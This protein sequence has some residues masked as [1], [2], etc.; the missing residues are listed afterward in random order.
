M[1]K[2]NR[3]NP[4]TLNL[5]DHE[6]QEI[7]RHLRDGKPLPEKYRF[8]LFEDKREVEL[9]WNGKTNHVCDVELPFQTIERVDEP[10]SEDVMKAQL[11]IMDPSSGRQSGGWYNK[12]IWGD[13]NLILSSLIRGP[14]REQIEEAGGLKLI[15]I[16]PPFDVGADFS[17][18]IKVGDG[19]STLTKSPNVLEEIAYRDTWGR[20][21][22]SF[23]AMI[24]ERL[25]LMRELLADDGSIY[26]HCDWRL[27]SYLRI[28][29]NEVFGEAYYRNEIIW[30][31]DPTGKG[32][33]RISNQLPKEYDSI[34]FYS[35][36][37][38]YTF[39]QPYRE[40]SDKQKSIYNKT[41]EG[42]GRKFKLVTLG[43]Y[44]QKS[45]QEMEA[46]NLIY[47]TSSGTKYKKYYLDESMDTVGSI[48]ADLKVSTGTKAKESFGYPTQKT[49]DLLQRIIEASSN[50]GDLIA[51]FFC[52]SGTT[53]AVAEKLGRKWIASDLGKFAIHTTR[54][55]LIGVQR[56]L[57][58]EN[59]S[60]RAFEIL[61][62]GKYERQY[63]LT[64]H[65]PQLSEEERQ[66][67]A[68]RKRDDYIRQILQAYQAEPVQNDAVLHGKKGAVGV[69]VGP[70]N[71]P[72]S[73]ADVEGLLDQCDERKITAV[74]ILAFE[75]EMNLFPQITD[76]AKQR[77]ITLNPKYIPPEVFD[78]RAVERGQVSFYDVA[79][80]EAEASMDKKQ[81]VSV[82]LT[83]FS[84]S[85]SQEGKPGKVIVE[86]GQIYQTDKKGNRTLL[87]KH[88]SDWVDYWAVDYNYDGHIFKNEWQSF[89]ARNQKLELSSA[90][91]EVSGEN[92]K[93][94][95]KVV[96]ILGS[97]TLKIVEI[98]SKASRK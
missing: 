72:V 60:Y 52:G 92:C 20:G 83:N 45:I 32:A 4:K 96:D 80:I 7:D 84:T 19:G 40:L 21:A 1:P 2:P 56:H 37:D 16:D 42:T 15:Y 46:I 87:T 53:A 71:L 59:K 94:A 90:A 58:Q 34:L 49:E 14:L 76:T 95:V 62:L 17:M 12:L 22:D 70:I 43:D 50:A 27:N 85:Y 3:T 24:Y 25:V 78:K 48:W 86:N 33:K 55:R 81:R 65:H 68:E 82:K 13:N 39:N 29:L 74:D 26:V 61:N 63:Y 64:D 18:D 73:R 98:A 8:R 31:R 97:D 11:S 30:Q 77:G 54:K 67:L 41:E 69:V 91:K 88:W 5:T 57:K 23:I 38:H 10:R 47:T 93:I 35:K 51:D 89:R 6:R 9:V 44:S 28:V 79:Y 66:R 36:S 75:F